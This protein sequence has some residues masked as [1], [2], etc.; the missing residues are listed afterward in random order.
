MRNKRL[1][2]S[3][4]LKLRAEQSFDDEVLNLSHQHWNRRNGKETNQKLS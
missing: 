1:A 4:Y 3:G 2:G